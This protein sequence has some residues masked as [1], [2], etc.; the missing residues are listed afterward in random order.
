MQ[1]RGPAA[2]LPL[3]ADTSQAIAG[4]LPE[5]PPEVSPALKRPLN[6]FP[7][8]AATR[9]MIEGTASHGLLRVSL[10]IFR[11]KVNDTCRGI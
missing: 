9:S 5:L 1:L 4:C 7:V 3:T 11:P 6:A 8:I 2:D 10:A